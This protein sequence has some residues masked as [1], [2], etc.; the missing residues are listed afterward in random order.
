M[1][2]TP[3]TLHA[4]APPTAPAPTGAAPASGTPTRD[5][6]APEVTRTIVLPGDLQFLYC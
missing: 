2:D 4:S 5:P 3:Q 1:T 6:H